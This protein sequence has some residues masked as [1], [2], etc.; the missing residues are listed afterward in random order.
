MTRTIQKYGWKPSLPDPRDAFFFPPDADHPSF[1]DEFS[2]RDELPA[3]LDQGNLGS[4]TANA[5]AG[6]LEYA[7]MLEGHDFGVPS[8]LFI[9]YMERLAEGTVLQDSGAYGR[10]GFAAL[11][12]VGAPSEE[13]WPYDVAKFTEKPSQE[14][15]DEAGTHRIKHYTAART[16]RAEVKHLITLKKPVAFGFS[17]PQEFEGE[18]CMSTGIM[19]MPGPKPVWLGGHEVYVFG[20][21]PDETAGVLWECRNSWSDS[22][23]DQGNFWLPDAFLFGGFA[24]DFRAIQN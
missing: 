22:V 1:P 9:Y 15:Y 11:R 16:H 14:A 23:M 18:Q 12:S 3:V 13:I 20:W 10:D 5:L 19:P 17:V 8:R 7:N 24:S 21:K 2:L 6:I 4:C